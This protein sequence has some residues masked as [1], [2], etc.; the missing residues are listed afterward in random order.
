MTKDIHIQFNDDDFEATSGLSSV[1][2]GVWIRIMIAMHLQQTSTL[3]GSFEKIARMTRCTVQ[4]LETACNEFVT[5]NVT[6]VKRECNGDVTLTHHRAKKRESTLNRVRKYR[7]R[8]AKIKACNKN[9]TLFNGDFD[10]DIDNIDSNNI[11][12]INN[13]IN[14]I[15]NN[16]PSISP[17]S[18]ECNLF[19]TCLNFEDFWN[20]YGKKVERMKCEKIFAKI[21][22]ADREKIKQHV[23]VYVASTPDPKYRKNP[24]TYLNGQCWNDEII[25]ESDN[26]NATSGTYGDYK[27]RN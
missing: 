1:A 24:Q 15:Y 21:K 14:N 13:N 19:V 26:R 20:M 6:L 23:P 4:E 22:E 16:T 12:N 18:D 27:V 17:S 2:M 10:G 8:Q 5:D 7:E 25:T 11:Y 9:V 3:T